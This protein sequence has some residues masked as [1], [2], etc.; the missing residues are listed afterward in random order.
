MSYVTFV[1]FIAFLV[2][3]HNISEAARLRWRVMIRGGAR[4]SSALKERVIASLILLV[5]TICLVSWGVVAYR[6][7]SSDGDPVFAILAWLTSVG[8]GSFF[9]LRGTYRALLM[10][11]EAMKSRRAYSE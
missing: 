2:I 1:G 10:F 6:M 11:R 3:W 5:P 4:N 7:L 8:V 9:L